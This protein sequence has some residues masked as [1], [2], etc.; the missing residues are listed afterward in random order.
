MRFFLV[1]AWFFAIVPVI[2]V[3]GD[4][5]AGAGV[6]LSRT[7]Q[8]E[9]DERA[10]R[11]GEQLDLFEEGTSGT[12]SVPLY[13]VAPIAPAEDAPELFHGPFLPDDGSAGLFRGPHDPQDGMSHI[14]HEPY[15][16]LGN[17]GAPVGAEDGRASLG[18]TKQAD[19]L[20]K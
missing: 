2:A 14:F 20:L 1:F 3:A 6:S 10:R 13:S 11:V 12:V 5:P 4:P 16:L 19:S 17:T 18:I 7:S 15:R 8:A 9:S